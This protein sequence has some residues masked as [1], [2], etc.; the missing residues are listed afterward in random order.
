MRR[1]GDQS[2]RQTTK[3]QR[4]SK[5]EKYLQ[6]EGSSLHTKILQ[7][8]NILFALQGFHLVSSIKLRRYIYSHSVCYAVRIFYDCIS[9]D[10]C[11][12]ISY[13]KLVNHSNKCV[14]IQFVRQSEYFPH[15]K[16]TQIRRI[17][18]SPEKPKAD[19]IS[20][21]LSFPEQMSQ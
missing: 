4:C 6:C 19:R 3:S 16:Y 8:A 17:V 18:A 21:L 7:A 9:M 15:L 1:D 20:L 2:Q 14:E 13:K 12:C 11:N 10:S 5:E